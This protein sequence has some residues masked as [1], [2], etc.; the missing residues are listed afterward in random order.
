MRVLFVVAGMA[1]YLGLAIYGFG[2]FAAFFAQPALI[3]LA[4]AL[5][6]ITVAAIFAGG[7]LSTGE[8]EDRSN[9]W[10]LI[11]FA[12]IGF[13]LGFVPAYTDRIGFL[14]IDGDAIRWLGVVLFAIGGAL[15]IW[16]I[17]VLGNRF[18]GLV[19]IQRGHQLVTTGVYGAIRNPS[20]A[21]LLLNCIGWSLAFRS[22]VGLI[23]TALLVPPLLSRIRSEEALL[24]SHFGAE[25]DAYRKHTSR[26]IPGIY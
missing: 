16:P 22:G 13:A 25:Y 24:A 4:V 7:E 1:G 6:V 3:A 19:A 23:M 14:T 18:S 17:Y 12:A 20:Y 11:P 8:R 21:G 5:L 2:G 26:L 10:V 9:R 15:R